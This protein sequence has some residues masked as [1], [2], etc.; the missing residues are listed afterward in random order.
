MDRGTPIRS[1]AGPCQS[2]VSRSI[3]SVRLAL[4]TSVTCRPPSLPPVR[5]HRT[6]VSVVPNASSP[7]SARSRAPSTLS[8]SQVIL[9][10]EKYVDRGRPVTSRSRSTPSSPAS[11]RTSAPVRVSCQTIALWIGSPVSRSHTTVVSRWLVMPMASTSPA[12]ASE[13][14]IAPPITWRVRRQISSASC[15]THPARGLI[16]SCSRW[17]M[18]ATEP[19]SSKRM[20]R[21]LVVPWSIAPTYLLTRDSM[22]RRPSRRTPAREAFDEHAHQGDRI[23]FAELLLAGQ[24]APGPERERVADRRA[25]PGRRTPA[26]AAAGHQD[27]LDRAKVAVEVAEPLVDH[28]HEGLVAQQAGVHPLRAAVERVEL[29]QRGLEALGR[30]LDPGPG[31]RVGRRVRGAPV[32]RAGGE[33]RLLV[34]EVA[35][36]GRAAHAGAVGDRADRS[37]RGTELLVERDGALGDAGA[38]P[39]LELGSPLHPVGALFIGHICRMDLDTRGGRPLPFPRHYCPT[40]G[41]R[42]GGD[43]R[44]GEGR[45]SPGREGGLPREHRRPVHDRRGGGGR[46]LLARRAPDVA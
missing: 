2:S 9:G 20:K 38:R 28:G 17:S 35:V 1:S 12:S 15:S 22:P 25:R 8:S 41:S 14:A 21:E 5:F 6:Q 43:S 39:L 34:G 16:C 32:R 40:K 24:G 10:P 4:V 45:G 11:S 33:Q 29:A 13:S 3:S 37:P 7:F 27:V 36:D 42:H 30:G 44:S 26:Q 46:A 23:A 19:S 18:W 31:P